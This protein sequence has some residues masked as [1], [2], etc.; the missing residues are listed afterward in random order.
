MASTMP[1]PTAKQS[2]STNR[3][4]DG[5]VSVAAG[6]GGAS[7]KLTPKNALL[8]LQHVLVSNVWLDPVFVAGAIGLPLALSSNM[9]NAIFIVSGLVTLIQ[10]TKLVRLPIVQGPSAAFDALMI[11]AGTA[12]SLAAAG[13][14]IFISSL[15]F[16]VLCLT[17]V[18]EKLRFLFAPIVSGVVIFL[19]GVSLSS[20]TLS[21]FLGGAPGD[22]GFADPKTLAVSI[23][24][25]VLVV[26]LS[27]FGKGMAKALSYLI[28]LVVGTAMS[29]AFGMADFSEVSFKPWFGLPKFM[30]YG[31]FDFNAAV[32][33][34]FLI[35][36]LVAIMEALGVYQAATEIQGTKLENRQVRYGLAG[37]AAGS[38]I[39]SLIGGFT[40]TAYPQ[41][42]ALLKVTDEGR[43]RTRVPV[44]IAG[45]VFVVLGFIPKAGAVL[46]LIP[47]PVIGGIFLPAA[48]SLISTGFNTLRK[49]EGNDRN[50]VVIG[51]SLLLGI[52]LPNALS[53]LEGG[54]H[55][56]FSNSIL[57]GA[58]SVVILKALIIDLPDMIARR[59]RTAER[60]NQTE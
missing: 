43:T 30:P 49:V 35:A 53:G 57:V 34:P 47:S 1:S 48:A 7:G 51:L 50:Q 18:I 38:A 8:G 13:T 36:Y 58:F 56:F 21:E 20:F 54:A 41:N 16:L 3:S 22:K 42:V 32:F 5:A 33:V 10:A 14:S 37:E 4:Q 12:G 39:S 11:A 40:T 6:D 45:V 25:C 46:S 31:G 29:L 59:A 28:A 2:Q 55:V 24:T 23:A 60:T 26:A 17:R 19:V 9:V 44:I 27:Q 52:A 15:I